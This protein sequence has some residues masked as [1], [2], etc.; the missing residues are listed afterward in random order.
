MP[1]TP[2]H[3]RTEPGQGQPPP[4]GL[5]G[6][7]KRIRQT[8][9]RG[10]HS[11]CPGTGR[12]GGRKGLW[13]LG[14]LPGCRWRLSAPAQGRGSL[15]RWRACALPARRGRGLGSGLV[16]V[17]VACQPV[18]GNTEG[19]A[20]GSS[21]ATAGLLSS[22]VR[23]SLQSEPLGVA[24]GVRVRPSLRQP[25]ACSPRIQEPSIGGALCG[26]LGSGVVLVR[27][28]SALFGSADPVPETQTRYPTWSGRLSRKMTRADVGTSWISALMN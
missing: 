8:G 3:P 27:K 18:P 13:E 25:P 19:A 7:W 17:C 20:P 2:G 21:A 9:S 12:K 1:P 23:R 11:P 14:A 15:R 16:G 5:R 28:Q 6:G 10:R 4:R 22:C 26:D 24:K